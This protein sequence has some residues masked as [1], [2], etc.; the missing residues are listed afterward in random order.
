MRDGLDYHTVK[1]LLSVLSEDVEVAYRPKCVQ[2]EYDGD[3]YVGC[4][5]DRPQF[6]EP[7]M[8]KVGGADKL[9]I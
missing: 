6:H 1:H 4:L 7:D 2:S 8:S 3:V 9:L 5:Q